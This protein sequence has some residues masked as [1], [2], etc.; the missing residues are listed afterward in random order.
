MSLKFAK[1]LLVVPAPLIRHKE[2]AD[3]REGNNSVLSKGISKNGRTE[4]QTVEGTDG[5][6]D[7]QTDEQTRQK[8]K[9]RNLRK[10]PDKTEKFKEE[11]AG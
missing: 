6:T 3:A 1:H 2:A 8:K 4:E 11:E 10:E 7:G 5:R 9:K